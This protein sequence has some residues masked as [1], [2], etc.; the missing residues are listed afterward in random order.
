MVVQDGVIHSSQ[1]SVDFGTE[2]IFDK[3]LVLLVM[4]GRSGTNPVSLN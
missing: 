3:V 1:T 2:S 4:N